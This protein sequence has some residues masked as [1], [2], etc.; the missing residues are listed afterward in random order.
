MPPEYVQPYVKAQKNDERDAEVIAEAATRPTMRFVELKTEEQLDAQILHRARSR[1]NQLRAPLQRAW[2]QGRSGQLVQG[3][4]AAP[5]EAGR[6]SRTRRN[7]ADKAM[8]SV[9]RWRRIEPMGPSRAASARPCRPIRALRPVHAVEN[10]SQRQEP[11][12]LVRILRHCR[13]ATELGR[14]IVRSQ[15]NR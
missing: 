11:P 15:T 12:A 13:Q 9:V 3:S 4:R 5:L 7:R 14:R 2:P 8:H 10:R 6:D 1:L